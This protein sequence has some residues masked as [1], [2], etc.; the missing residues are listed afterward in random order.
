MSVI[1]L[2]VV[3]VMVGA[4]VHLAILFLS[5]APA[6]AFS[7]RHAAGINN[8]VV[9]EFTQGWRLFAPNVPAQNTQVQARAKV[10]MPDGS[11]RDTDW[12][13]LTARDQKKV[14]HNPFPSHVEQ[15][16]L[17]L[18]WANFVDTRDGQGR[19][20][21]SIGNLTQKYL[22]RIVAHRLGQN[23]DG[24]T[25]IVVQVRTAT[26]PVGAP[27][28]SNQKTDTRTSYLVQPWWVVQAEDFK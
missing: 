10:L 19:P 1:A 8:Y 22:L 6:N 16:E 15:N 24:G 13:D 11:L 14:L 20:I 7:Q 9:P 3:G 23:I 27:P 4:V 18:G 2:A 17:R 21:G 25:V 28:W 5:I 26:N 12:V